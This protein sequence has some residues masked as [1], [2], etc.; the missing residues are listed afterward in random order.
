MNSENDKD[1]PG[2][3]ERVKVTLY[4]RPRC[5]LC[6]EAK[7]A[8]RTAV[9]AGEFTLEEVNIDIDPELVRRFG[10]DIPVISLDGIVVFKRRVDPLEFCREILE[11]RSGRA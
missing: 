5:H 4:T 7:A 2:D 10:W 9:C 1:A 3:G 11:R 8:I 6:D